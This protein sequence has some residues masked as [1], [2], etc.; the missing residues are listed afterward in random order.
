M[1]LAASLEGGYHRQ[2]RARDANAV[3]VGLFTCRRI[4]FEAFGCAL[5]LRIV[6]SS[7]MGRIYR[8]EEQQN[9]VTHVFVS[10]KHAQ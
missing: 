5:R 3:T 1:F 2:C 4:L 9:A 6:V 7:S 8:N 10:A